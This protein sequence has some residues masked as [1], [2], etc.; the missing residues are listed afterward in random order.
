[1]V[2]QPAE[3]SHLLAATVTPEIGGDELVLEV[4]SGSGVVAAQLRS[5]AGATVV[6]TD[7]NPH[8]CAATAARGVPVVR[9]DLVAPF[10]DGVFDVV[11]FNPPYLP[12]HP[13]LDRED[14]LEVAVTGGPEGRAVID[15]FLHDVARVLAER[16]RVFLLV[17][18]LTGVDS[19]VE[20]AAANGFSAAAIGEESFPF[21][22]LTV[23]KLW[24]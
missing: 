12:S 15:R 19:V 5:E 20:T 2:Y 10:A 24:R 6:A 18:S 21:E 22:T 17:S 11:V 8:A 7:V 14:W 9:A 23:L 13:D 16:G 3:D 1:M 4:G